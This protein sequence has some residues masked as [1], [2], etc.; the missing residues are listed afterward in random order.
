[1]GT[2]VAERKWLIA[3][4]HEVAGMTAGAATKA[5]EM[6]AAACA[7]KQKLW[8]GARASGARASAKKAERGGSGV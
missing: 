2:E 1:M 3:K 7:E 4:W 5:G 8:E 6:D